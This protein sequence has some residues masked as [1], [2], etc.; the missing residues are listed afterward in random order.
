MSCLI[1]H[2]EILPVNMELLLTAKTTP[3]LNT[4]TCP[5]ISAQFSA[6]E[7]HLLVTDYGL[8][9]IEVVQHVYARSPF[10]KHIF[11]RIINYS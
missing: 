10:C 5:A 7:T 2:E 6:S 4:C 11:K 8:N 3:G 1:F 9:E